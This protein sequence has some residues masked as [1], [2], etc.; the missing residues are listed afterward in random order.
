MANLRLKLPRSSDANGSADSPAQLSDLIVAKRDL[1]AVTEDQ[2]ERVAPKRLGSS[3]MFT[4]GVGMQEGWWIGVRCPIIGWHNSHIGPSELVC[5]FRRA[6]IAATREH[7][8]TSA[9][10]ERNDGLM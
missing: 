9:R 4:M 10:S 2:G 6:V 5:P 8:W 3:A 1:I 7:G